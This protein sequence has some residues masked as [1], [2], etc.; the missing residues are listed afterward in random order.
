MATRK[1]GSLMKLLRQ[2]GC[3]NADKLDCGENAKCMSSQ[4]AEEFQDTCA[5]AVEIEIQ[6]G[7]FVS[8]LVEGETTNISVT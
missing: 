5:K 4:A 1:F 2:S 7:R 8:A 6:L 3:P